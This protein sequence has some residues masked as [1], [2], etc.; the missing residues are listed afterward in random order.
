MRDFVTLKDGW[1]TIFFRLED[2]VL[3]TS[4]SDLKQGAT[5]YLS[6]GHSF[7]LSGSAWVELRG[8]LESKGSETPVGSPE[9]RLFEMETSPRAEKSP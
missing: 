8:M 9:N 7:G 5:V 3:V 2:I 4:C 1:Q 6:G